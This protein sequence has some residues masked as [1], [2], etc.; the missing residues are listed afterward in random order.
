MQDKR[1][2]RSTE[3]RVV[4]GVAGGMAEYFEIDPVIIRV[5]FVALALFGGGGLL[6]Y[7][8]LWI[9][10]PEQRM[11]KSRAGSYRSFDASA[12]SSPEPNPEPSPMNTE[13]PESGHGH[14][15]TRGSIIA[16]VILIT[17]GSMFL[18]DNFVPRINFGDIWPFILVV[19]GIILLATSVPMRRDDNKKRKP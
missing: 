18:I 3:S 6:I 13:H 2:Y 4:A 14:N 17:L 8:V 10:L 15:P 7:V 9:V 1:L 5:L 11:L 12:E 16:G 19:I